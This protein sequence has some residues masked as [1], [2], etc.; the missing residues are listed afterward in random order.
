MPR[1]G[2]APGV[3]ASVSEWTA[4]FAPNS[5]RWRSQPPSP[6]TGCCARRPPSCILFL[7]QSYARMEYFGMRT[8]ITIDDAKVDELMRLNGAASRSDAIRQAV[9]EAIRRRK[10]ADFMK[11]AGKFPD[12]PTNEEIEREQM[13]DAK[14]T[15]R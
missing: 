12:F 6:P 9:E 5:T 11:L 10:V 1:S 8:T 13:A 14:R 7:D 2:C 4:I 15:H 3:A